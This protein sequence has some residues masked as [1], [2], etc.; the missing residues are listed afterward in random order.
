MD[1][2][3]EPD[4]EVAEVDCYLRFFPNSGK[5]VAIARNDDELEANADPVFLPLSQ[6]TVARTGRFHRLFTD[7]EIIRVTMPVWMAE[8]KNLT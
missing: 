2:D 3:Y 4:D 5:S 1:W 8:D 7:K 6:I